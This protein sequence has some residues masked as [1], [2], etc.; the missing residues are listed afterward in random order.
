M[1]SDRY[2]PDDLR[3]PA[4]RAIHMEQRRAQLHPI[5]DDLRRLA[6][7]MAADI[8]ETGPIEGDLPG[9]ARLRAWNVARPLFK[10]ADDIERALSDVLAFH[11]RYQRSYEELPER[12]AEKR[13][14]K[15][16]AKGEQPQA[17]EP[18]PAGTATS[19]TSPTYEDVF[20]S[21]RKGA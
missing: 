5:A 15:A 11:A 7:E 6:R 18:S 14:R 21:L 20:D 19:P 12:R 9:Q 4:S 1:S 16:L 13:E 3:S 10:A 17:I 8:A 2:T